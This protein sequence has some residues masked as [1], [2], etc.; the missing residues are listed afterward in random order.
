MAGISGKKAKGAYLVE[1][2]DTGET[3]AEFY[4]LAPVLVI[5]PGGQFI[6]AN[7]L[8]DL[9]EHI[10]KAVS[11]QMQEEQLAYDIMARVFLEG[12]SP[13]Y[14]ELGNEDNTGNWRNTFWYHSDS[15]M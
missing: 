12:P 4:P 7:S 15:G 5:I 13:L 10:L 9:Q 11:D 8:A 1:I 3:K 6:A 2:D 14:A